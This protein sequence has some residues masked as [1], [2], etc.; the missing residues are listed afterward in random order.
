[1]YEYEKR[2]CLVKGC[3]RADSV[4]GLCASH[5]QAAWKLVNV[6]KKTTWERLE[7]EGRCLQRVFHPVPCRD[8]FLK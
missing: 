5:Y 6:E 2:K 1:M 8:F 7:K 3:N 4:R